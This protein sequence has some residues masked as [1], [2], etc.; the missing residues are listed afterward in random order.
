MSPVV[1]RQSKSWGPT[2][3]AIS[4]GAAS[5]AL[6]SQS[7]LLDLNVLFKKPK[8]REPLMIRRGRAY[9]NHGIKPLNY[10]PNSARN[11]KRR[12]FQLSPEC[13][14]SENGRSALHSQSGNSQ[15]HDGSVHS[16]GQ[17]SK[18][19]TTGRKCSENCH[20][21][22]CPH[23]GQASFETCP[24][25]VMSRTVTSLSLSSEPK[26][27]SLSLTP[28]DGSLNPTPNGGSRNPTLTSS[29]NTTL[30]GSR[31]PTL[32]GSVLA[33][34]GLRRLRA[35]CSEYLPGSG[36]ACD[37]ES[38]SGLSVLTWKMNHHKYFSNRH[39]RPVFPRLNIPAAYW[40][41]PI[42]PTTQGF[43]R[44]RVVSG[45]WCCCCWC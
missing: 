10:V 37:E 8:M 2:P 27:W 29:P 21:N 11:I 33:P 34:E 40:S 28:K 31:H 15:C 43:F 18:T 32:T 12:D 1:M 4:P 42:A 14:C 25:C 6:Y 36:K 17:W 44:Q 39:T 30:T 24:I 23:E 26:D 22:T 5:Q 13:D 16:S 3:L 19:S 9:P 20:P 41:R 7:P 45:K 38:E 35:G